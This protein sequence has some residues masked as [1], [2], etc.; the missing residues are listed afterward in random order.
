[1]ANN[2]IVKAYHPAGVWI[3]KRG[4]ASST[5]YDLRAELYD[6]LERIIKPMETVKI[7][8]GLMIA[9]EDGLCAFIL[10]RSSLS[11]KGLLVHTGTIDNDYRGELQVCITNLNSQN[12]TIADGERIAQLVFAKRIDVDWQTATD[13]EWNTNTE[14]GEGGFGSTGKMYNE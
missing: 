2:P 4:T 3:P 13:E 9:P 10:P 12:Y 11:A 7:S 6:A 1:M 8:T 14:R 5:G